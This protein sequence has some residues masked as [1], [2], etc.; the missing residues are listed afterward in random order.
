MS[1]IHLG[2]FSVLLFN[3]LQI[4]VFSF[5]DFLWAVVSVNHL[6]WRRVFLWLRASC[7]VFQLNSLLLVSCLNPPERYIGCFR[8]YSR[9]GEGFCKTFSDPLSI[10]CNS[11][12]LAFSYRCQS[13]SAS[14]FYYWLIFLLYILRLVESLGHL[15]HSF[16][17]HLYGEEKTGIQTEACF[18]LILID[19][20]G[21]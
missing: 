7:W 18:R 15:L 17:C 16:S 13:S 3:P 20:Y 19:F 2:N 12:A 6:L 21:T 11:S 9:R 1:I 4:Q 10:C 8:E 14:C 5:C